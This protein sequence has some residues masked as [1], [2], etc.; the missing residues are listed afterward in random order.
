MKIRFVLLGILAMQLLLGI[1]YSFA[2]PL[3]QGHER[4]YYNVIRFLDQNGRLPTANDYP[5]DD[6]EI[7]QATQPPLY[8]LLAYPVAA[9]FR[10]DEPV[11]PGVQ[12]ALICVGDNDL[13]STLI[14][15]PITQS[16]IPPVSGVAAAGYALRLLNVV[17][18]MVGVVFTYLVAHTLF[19][20][21][22]AIALVAAALLAF[23]GSMVHLN[24]SISNDALLIT[25][26]AAN[27]TFCAL[28][29]QR[30]QW[31]TMAFLLLTVGLA[32]MTRL[33]GWG[34]LAFDLPFVLIVALVQARTAARQHA[35]TL[36]LG[37][38]V[39]VLLAAGVL[40]F[41]QLSYGS[42]FGRYSSL[43]DSISARL[44][45]LNL[46]LVAVGGVLRLTY[47][48]YQEPMQALRTRAIFG[49]LYGLL[50]AMTFVGILWGILRVKPAER[51]SFLILLGMVF[52][53]AALVIFR[54]ALGATEVNTTSYNTGL[55]FAP[56]RYYAAGLPAAA[57]LFSAGL[58][59]LLPQSWATG[60]FN[61]PGII[62]AGCWLLVSAVSGISALR[63]QPAS[64]VLS[65]ANY[66]ALSNL[67]IVDA[68]PVPD[69][70][71]L[72]AY[73]VNQRPT[74]GF[75]DLT[76]YLTASQPLPLNSVAEISLSNTPVPCQ[77]LPT[78][79]A[80]PTTLWLPGEIIAASAVIPV[81]NLSD[82]PQELSLRWLGAST[83]GTIVS[84][85]TTPIT[86]AT[87]NPG[88]GKA[89]SCPDN[90][91]VLAS[92]YQVIKF[93]SPPTIR[94]SE[95]YLPSVN[96]LVLAPS[97]E[98]AAR[99]FTFTHL[100]TGMTYTCDG[101]PAPEYYDITRYVR[102]EEIFFDSCSITFPTDAPL[103]SYRVSIAAIAANGSLLPA[104]NDDGQP[105]VDGILPV[106]EVTLIS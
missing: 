83:D 102:G 58:F 78:R 40:I 4:D 35:R 103:G 13:N 14:N 96:W 61:L 87:L 105:A 71:T 41:N 59:A 31:R 101:S 75:V 104:V 11:P 3:W 90:L 54:N 42:I 1:V 16:Y 72:L 17:I 67:T 62:V 30:F 82:S 46:P 26:S 5:A 29:A 80:Y 27:L 89:A 22:P 91:G 64:P 99:R 92:G 68:A 47:E 93:N 6:A 81:C 77:F 45:T 25:L 66:A 7:R 106:G 28:L 20:N 21:R 50:L 98:I 34:L 19:P 49:T 24:S 53:A 65:P 18:G 85:E 2:T 23:E 97:S 63:S 37:A 95:T 88:F 70:P 94:P 12:P 60:R 69:V 48:A 55:I 84:S 32:L 100:D 86:L 57:I 56:I 10:S 9:L 79:G 51:R 52:A 39:L 8:F 33:G 36:L 76:L 38:G 43:T 73:H 15:Y 44:T 74:E